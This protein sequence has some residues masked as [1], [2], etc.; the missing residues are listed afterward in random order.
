M[1]R[2]ASKKIKRSGRSFARVTTL[3]TVTD[4]LALVFMSLGLLFMIGVIVILLVIKH[5]VTVIGKT[6][7]QKAAVFRG[8]PYIVKIALM[9]AR[10]AS[11][12]HPA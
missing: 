5:K 8:L 7:K 6:V 11:R 10:R 1:P 2:N 4:E 12:N 3:Q 9:A